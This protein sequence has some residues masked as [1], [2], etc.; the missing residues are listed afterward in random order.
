MALL[1]ELKPGVREIIFLASKPT[2][3]FPLLVTKA[4]LRYHGYRRQPWPR[5][6]IVPT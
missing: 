2:D 4:R 6:M 1:G 5:P 3:E